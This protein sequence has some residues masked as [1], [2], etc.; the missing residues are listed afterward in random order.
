MALK[1]PQKLT[2]FRPAVRAW[3]KL[4][5]EFI[6]AT[7][8]NGIESEC[9]LVSVLGES[10]LMSSQEQEKLLLRAE[11]FADSFSSVLGRKIELMPSIRLNVDDVPTLNSRIKVIDDMGYE[12]LNVILA[13]YSRFGRN[14]LEFRKKFNRHEFWIHASESRRIWGRN[15]KRMSWMH[16]LQ[17]FGMDTFA[18]QLPNHWAPRPP[19]TSVHD[20]PIPEVKV[21]D[22][23]TIAIDGLAEFVGRYG[24]RIKPS[25]PVFKGRNFYEFAPRMRRKKILDQA[26]KIDEVFS[27]CNQFVKSRESIRRNESSDYIKSKERLDKAVRETIKNQKMLL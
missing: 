21:F 9:D 24:E 26:C 22:E 1:V 5:M 13:S 23:N 3:D 20:K 18:L 8:Q 15:E 2:I 11:K 6:E 16:M 12:H 19:R 7:I 4:S 10:P 25:S 27:S 17:Y 14:Y